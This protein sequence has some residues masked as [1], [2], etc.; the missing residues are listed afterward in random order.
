MAVMAVCR[1][2]T[3][4]SRVRDVLA[5]LDLSTELIVVDDGSVDGTGERAAVCGVRVGAMRGTVRVAGN[6][7]GQLGTVARRDCQRR[8]SR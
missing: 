7:D 3:R 1:S 2:V 4:L 8:E 5:D 6:P